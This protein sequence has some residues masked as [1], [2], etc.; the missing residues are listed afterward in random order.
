MNP[1]LALL[2]AAVGYLTGSISFSRLVARIF[3]PHT[4]IART[5]IKL[6]ASDEAFKVS[7]VSPTAVSMQLGP[8][9]GMIT[10]LLD[11]AKV[12]VPTLAIKL[13]Y[14][15]TPY[16]LI[17]ALACVAG[18]AWPLY[19]RFRGGRGLSAIYAGMLVIDWTGVLV[20]ALGGFLVSAFVFKQVLLTFAIGLWLLVP[21]LW[22][23][24][25]D[26]GYVAYAL[27]AIILFN[28]ASI[29]EARQFLRL[30]REGRLWEMA[31]TMEQHT[32]MWRG[33]MKVARRLGVDPRRVS[34]G[35]EAGAGAATREIGDQD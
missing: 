32:G 35:P 14:P 33:M 29:P 19:H 24:T 25:H 12:I 10:V 15:N 31:A 13:A 9:F 7:A 11:M 34:T 17:T 21:W 26:L 4:D 3:A 27:G 5:E 2:S 6:A 30:Q 28:V 23:R 18:H 1:Y 20:T 8:R 16:Y 22:F